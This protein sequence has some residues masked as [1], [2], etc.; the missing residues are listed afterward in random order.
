M[1]NVED[2]FDFWFSMASR[3]QFLDELWA[4]T[5]A[6]PRRCDAFSSPLEWL[7]DLIVLCLCLMPI[8]R[9]HSKFH[10]VYQLVQSSGTRRTRLHLSRGR[11]SAALQHSA[12]EPVPLRRMRCRVGAQVHCLVQTIKTENR[13]RQSEPG[14][15]D[16]W[17]A[18]I[19]KPYNQRVPNPCVFQGWELLRAY[20][21]NETA[22]LRINSCSRLFWFCSRS[23]F[24][25]TFFSSSPLLLSF[26]CLL[27]INSKS[28]TR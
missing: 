3:K 8:R 10:N 12:P 18:Q 15:L 7:H 22:H 19:W 20:K 1:K 28:M 5:C 9:S 16:S 11:S 24:R 26:A 13:K 2:C 23:R 14:R 6:C 4:S 17:S 25:S 27:F 21:R